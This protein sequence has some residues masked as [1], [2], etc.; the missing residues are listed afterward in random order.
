[1]LAIVI[2]Y[3]KIRFFEATLQS[4]A[5]Q[6]DKRFKVYIGND[7]SN[8]DP[9]AILAKYQHQF[10]FEYRYYDTNLGSTSLT[11][12]WE[13]C[14]TQ[15]QGEDW[16]MILGDDDVLSQ[17]CIANFYDNTIEIEKHA[18]HVIRY[19]T[20]VIDENG[21]KISKIHKHPKLEKSTDFLMR[22]LKGG[23]RSSLSEFIF[24][25]KVLDTF[26]FKDFPLA[27]YSDYLAVLECTNFDYMFTI[28]NALVF[29]RLSGINITSKRDNLGVKN[30]GTFQFYYFLL[31]EKKYFFDS[32]QREIL[33]FNLEKTFLDNKKNK[34]FW[35]Q[36]TKLYLSK[37]YFKRYILF[38][39]KVKLAVFKK[40]I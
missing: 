25:K 23:T 10:D 5:L 13:R 31:K 8:D 30:L 26:Q 37:F 33:H 1:M 15:V 34:T 38:I 18:I 11:Q 39:N 24:R 35:V 14:L 16:V 21:K 3:Y 28:N 22:K 4:L 32:S 36:L 40:H 7:A 29:F 2:P 20:V 6:T 12:Q 19:A 27:W 9:A 17:N